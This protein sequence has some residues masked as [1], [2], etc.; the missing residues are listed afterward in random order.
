MV[1]L[2]SEVRGPKMKKA[3]TR[4]ISTEPPKELYN[5]SLDISPSFLEKQ[6]RQ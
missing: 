3:A 1:L 2:A 4:S 6:E 5:L